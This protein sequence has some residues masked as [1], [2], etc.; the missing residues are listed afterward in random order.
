[1]ISVSFLNEDD[2]REVHAECDHKIHAARVT[3]E[4]LVLDPKFKL[5]FNADFSSGPARPHGIAVK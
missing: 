4:Y 2:F 5:A 3:N 1:M